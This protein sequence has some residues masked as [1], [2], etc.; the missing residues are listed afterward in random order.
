MNLKRLLFLIIIF[1]F[2]FKGISRPLAQSNYIKVDNIVE[3]LKK[4]SQF[5]IKKF[6]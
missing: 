4:Q 3:K 5:Y 1:A 2:I 6:I